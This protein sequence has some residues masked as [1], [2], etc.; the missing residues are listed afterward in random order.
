LPTIA[1]SI[2]DVPRLVR[3]RAPLRLGLGGG[4][5]DLSPYCDR[6]G[7]YVLNATIDKYAYATI[8]AR[9]DGRVRLVA[10]DRQQAWEGSPDEALELDGTLDLHKGVYRRAVQ[11]LNGGRPLP[12]TLTTTLDALPGSGLGSSSTLVVAM[13]TAFAEWC[14]L[15]LDEY[16]TAQL[17]FEVERRD[18]GLAGGRQDQYAAAFGGVNFME[19]YAGDRV[20]VNPLRMNTWILSELEASLVL[21]YSGVSRDSSV[22][23]QEQCRRLLDDADPAAVD[24]MHDVKAGA[25]HMKESLL[26]GDLGSFVAEMNNTW[27]AKRRTARGISNPQLDGLHARAM[28]AGALGGKVSGAGGGGFLMF[29]VDPARRMDVLRAF[30]GVP[31]HVSTCHFTERGAHAWKMF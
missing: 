23:I 13:V 31:G 16:H 9:T 28:A 17:A 5:T 15:R 19:F 8:Q 4:G 7:G 10:A 3:A 27:Q 25:L 14:G 18:V 26:L 20:I 30:E 6:F 1:R 24:A 12:I 21:F 11:E 2:P 22:I 29:F